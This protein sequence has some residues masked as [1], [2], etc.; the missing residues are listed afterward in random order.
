MT[1][2]TA[3]ACMIS[4]RQ[5]DDRVAVKRYAFIFEHAFDDGEV[6]ADHL[7]EAL[8]RIVLEVER[9]PGKAF[10]VP[11]ARAHDK[12]LDTSIENGATAHGTGLAGAVE[13]AVR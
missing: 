6:P 8:H 13:H 3:L 10:D 4:A 1:C 7:G 2:S 12:R 5:L 9:E 11:V